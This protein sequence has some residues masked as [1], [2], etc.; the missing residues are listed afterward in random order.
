MKH[1]ERLAS[2]AYFAKAHLIPPLVWQGEIGNRLADCR[3]FR[4]VVGVRHPEARTLV[5]RCQNLLLLLLRQGI[6][7]LRVDG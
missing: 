4:V 7:F 2:A 1:H 6:R 3:S 5:L